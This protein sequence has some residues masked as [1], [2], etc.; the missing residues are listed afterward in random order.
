MRTSLIF[1]TYC[2]NVAGAKCSGEAQP[3]RPAEPCR[4]ETKIWQF[5]NKRKNLGTTFDPADNSS[6]EA[7][8][9]RLNKP[10][11]ISPNPPRHIW[12]TG[13]SSSS[14]SCGV[15]SRSRSHRAAR[16]AVGC[17]WL[18]ILTRPKS[19]SSGP[20]TSRRLPTRPEE[21]RCAKENAQ[22]AK[23]RQCAMR[24]AQRDAQGRVSL[25]RV[26]HI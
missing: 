8:P 7:T 4:D 5:S 21:G 16:T 23:G 17:K 12:E 26:P 25:A 19:F 18:F 14:S 13:S 20:F 11:H 1:T 10:C 15:R 24:N 22:C 2:P 6:G 3:N 9:N